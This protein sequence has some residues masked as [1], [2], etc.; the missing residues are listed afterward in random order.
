MSSHSGP[1][2]LANADTYADRYDHMVDAGTGALL[3]RFLVATIGTLLV[4][5]ALFALLRG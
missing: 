3:T 2:Q 1:D 4:T 5:G